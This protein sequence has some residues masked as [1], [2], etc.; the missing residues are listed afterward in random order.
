M[1]GRL[2]CGWARAM[3]EVLMVIAVIAQCVIR[4]GCTGDDDLPVCGGSPSHCQVLTKSEGS[5]WWQAK[6]A[7]SAGSKASKASNTLSA[8]TLGPLERERERGSE[9]GDV[10]E[11]SHTR[12]PLV[13][14]RLE[15]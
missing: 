14:R 6:P 9:C 12:D 2:D 1:T 3:A 10:P 11:E 13:F 4:L 15:G 7:G 5:C 8:I